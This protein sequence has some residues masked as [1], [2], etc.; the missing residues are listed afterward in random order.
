MGVYGASYNSFPSGVLLWKEITRIR[1]YDACEDRDR[2]EGIYI[3]IYIY[4]ERERD[5]ERDRE[6][7]KE[8]QRDRDRETETDDEQ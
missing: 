5:R 6:R 7:Q 2:Y 1:R 3:Y 4:I 8:R